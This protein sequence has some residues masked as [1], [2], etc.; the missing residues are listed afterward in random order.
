MSTKICYPAV[1]QKEDVGY[2]VWVP[3]IQGC[4]SQ[5]DDFEG[6]VN[7]ITEA[8]GI[9]LEDDLERGKKPPVPSAPDTIK[10]E[11]NQFLSVI[12]FDPVEY[13]KKYNTKAVKKT[14]TI[15]NWLNTMSENEN[16]NFSAV[17]QE[18]LMEKL[19]LTNNL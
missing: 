19:H 18:A 4:V 14:L 6:A 5:G 1:F 17:L 12:M 11:K 8:M 3:D 10:L 15:P 13:Q 2:S 7:Y 16:I 9:C